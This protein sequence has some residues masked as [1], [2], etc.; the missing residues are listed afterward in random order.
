MQAMETEAIELATGM[1]HEA[2]RLAGSDHVMV[3]VA[4]E[5]IA[6]ILAD[7]LYEIAPDLDEVIS[8]LPPSRRDGS[9]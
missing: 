9:H 7:L 3:R 1:L 2:R 5:R 6:V 8:L 4:G